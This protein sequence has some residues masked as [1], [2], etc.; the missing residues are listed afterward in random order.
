MRIFGWE[1]CG[2]DVRRKIQFNVRRQRFVFGVN[3]TGHPALWALV[4]GV[5]SIQAFRTAVQYG[6]DARI[7]PG[8]SPWVNCI[9]CVVCGVSLAGGAVKSKIVC[10][11]R[12]LIRQAAT[13]SRTFL[14]IA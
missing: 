7:I 4:L 2:S 12:G 9:F 10:K 6:H 8:T 5:A 11:S 14:P 13:R 3:V 1:R